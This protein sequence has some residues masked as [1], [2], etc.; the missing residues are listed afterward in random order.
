MNSKELRKKEREVCD[1]KIKYKNIIS[2]EYVLSSQGKSLTQD[3]YR[4]KICGDY[5]IFTLNKKVN[6][7]REDKILNN[8][9]STRIK[10]KLKK[11]HSRKKR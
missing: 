5:H 7:K 9:K 3:Y 11:G 10:Q 8:R 6:K 2:V 1:S 4:C